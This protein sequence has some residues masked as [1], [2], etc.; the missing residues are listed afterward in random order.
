MIDKHL[1]LLSEQ[2]EL[3]NILAE[4][5]KENIIER[6]G[7]EARLKDVEEQHTEYMQIL[8]LMQSRLFLMLSLLC[9]LGLLKN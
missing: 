6:L 1:Y 5:P 7:F 9:W 8:R 3:K 4:I 2:K